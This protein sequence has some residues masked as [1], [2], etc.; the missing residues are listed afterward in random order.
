M[1]QLISAA[2]EIGPLFRELHE[3]DLRR[4]EAPRTGEDK[5]NV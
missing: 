4:E 5:W 1:A 3:A 2:G